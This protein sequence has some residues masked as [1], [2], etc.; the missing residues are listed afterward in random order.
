MRTSP[1]RGRDHR[2]TVHEAVP[3]SY[4]HAVAD[5]LRSALVI[6]IH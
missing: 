6:R 3:D 5:G 4:D 2:H 1:C